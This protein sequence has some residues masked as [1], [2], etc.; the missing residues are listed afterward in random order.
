MVTSALIYRILHFFHFTL[1]IRE[2]CVFL[3]PLFSSFTVIITYLLTKE[4]KVKF[5]IAY[6][7]ISHLTHFYVLRYI[8]IFRVMGQA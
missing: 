8:K 3:A 2:V 1:H 4:L 5:F 7:Q 6:L